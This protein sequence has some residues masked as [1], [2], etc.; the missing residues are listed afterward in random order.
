MRG[1]HGRTPRQ[2]GQVR[3]EAAVTSL[4]RVVQP[5]TYVIKN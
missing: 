2:P 5:L 3:K 1:W 4:V